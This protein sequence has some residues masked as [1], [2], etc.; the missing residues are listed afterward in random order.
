MLG[1]V[2]VALA[3]AMVELLSGSVAGA[4]SDAAALITILRTGAALAFVGAV[5]RFALGPRGAQPQ[6]IVEGA[7]LE[8]S[9]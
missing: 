1:A 7:G 2:S 4:A 3:A 8:T 6:A 5:V 9:R